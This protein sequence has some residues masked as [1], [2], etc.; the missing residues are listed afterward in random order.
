MVTVRKLNLLCAS[1]LVAVSVAACAPRLDLRGNS[2]DPDILADIEVGRATKDQVSELLGSPSSIA[3]FGGESWYYI[4]ERT[5]TLAFF[6]PKVLERK[7]LIIRFDE[8]GVVT[9]L[10]SLG[11]DDGRDIQVVERET[12]TAGNEIT[13]LQQLFGNFGR[14]EGAGAQQG[15]G[16]GGIP[17]PGIPRR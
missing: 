13:F 7:V 11:L 2:P 8:E 4:S 1:F 5:E 6:E 12:P 15:S 17:G 16:P 3:P 10:D 14:F 9:E